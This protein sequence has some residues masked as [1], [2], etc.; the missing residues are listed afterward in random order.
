MEQQSQALADGPRQGRRPRGRTLLVLVL[1]LG[2]LAVAGYYLGYAAAPAA[3]SGAGGRIATGAQSLPV[4]NVAPV[5][6]SARPASLVLPGQYPGGNGSARAGARRGYIRKRYV[7]I[8]DRV[9]AGQVLAEIE[10]PELD[11]QILQAKA[12]VDQ[13]DTAIQQAQAS[14]EQGQANRNWPKSP[15]SAG[16]R[17]SRRV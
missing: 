6:R 11:Q 2:G 12:T 16:R 3:R 5:K 10:A 7:D 13:A 9:K 17:C 15:P 4:V 14:L 8:G 1:L